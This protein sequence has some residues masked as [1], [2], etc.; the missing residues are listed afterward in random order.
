MTRNQ[1]QLDLS[2]KQIRE[3]LPYDISGITL[4]EI[5]DDDS[6]VKEIISS[7][8]PGMIGSLQDLMSV[9]KMHE[10]GIDKILVEL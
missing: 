7:D 2:I 4:I 1:M 5:A 10:N 8:I 9:V 6:D 3:K